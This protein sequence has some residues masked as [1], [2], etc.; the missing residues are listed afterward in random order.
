MLCARRWASGEL[1]TGGSQGI[2]LG[3][4][5]GAQNKVV[6]DYMQKSSYEYQIHQQLGATDVLQQHS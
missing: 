1:F 6:N 5:R 2:C 4:F 3:H